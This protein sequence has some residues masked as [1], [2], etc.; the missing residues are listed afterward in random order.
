MPQ[1]I[2][3]EKAPEMEGSLVKR[4]H[5]E[6]MKLALS[7]LEEFSLPRGILLLADV[8]EAGFVRSTGYFWVRQQRGVE[9]YFK[10]VG[11][12]VSY[13]TEITGRIQHNS[14]KELKGVS[15]KLLLWLSINEIIIEESSVENIH[16]KGFGGISRTF[17]VEAFQLGE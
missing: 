9:H 8:T 15:A 10:K 1:I 5:D 7:V 12:L 14:I 4:G 17:P 6:G 16:F 13:E 3:Q 2:A 11:K